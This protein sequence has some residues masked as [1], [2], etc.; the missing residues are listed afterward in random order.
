[1]KKDDLRVSSEE[2]MVPNEEE[3]FTTKYSR[4]NISNLSPEG[5]DESYNMPE[6]DFSVERA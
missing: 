5:D 3:V 1:M 2:K 4:C 6:G